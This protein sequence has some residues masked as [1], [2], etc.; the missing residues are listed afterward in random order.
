MDSNFTVSPWPAG[1][2]AGSRDALIGRS[3]SN[4]VEHSRQ[5]N[6]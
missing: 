6:S 4:V 3:T 1:Q 5:R 2:A